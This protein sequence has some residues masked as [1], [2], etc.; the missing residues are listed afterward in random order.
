MI[1]L[2]VESP[3][4]GRT[5][6]RF[7]GKNYKVV[8][9]FGHVRDL[10][11][12][13]LG[14][15]VEKN[16]EPKYV[17]P[18]KA[19]KV[20]A[21]LKKEA[22]L[23]D[24][25]ILATDQ[26]REGE[27]ISWHLAEA[28]N[29]KDPKRIVFH[30]ITKSAIAEALKTPGKIDMH[31]VDAQQARRVLDR[32]VGYKLSPF[33]WKKISKGLSAGRVQSVAVRLVV[34]REE[35]IKKFIAEEYWEIEAIFNKENKNFS[36]FLIKK[37]GKIIDKLEIKNKKHADEILVGLE[38]AKYQIEKITKKETKRN[39]LPPFTTSTMQQTAANKFHFTAKM[40]M[41]VAQKLYEQGHITYHRTDS[42]NLS[43]SSLIA[44]EEFIKKSFGNDYFK[45]TLFKA[46]GNAQEAHEAIRPTYADKTPE[47]MKSELEGA[48]L[49]LYTL[50][51]QR[52]IAS[53]MTPAI[54]DS[55]SIEINGGNGYI[56]GANG[57]MLKFDGFLKIYPMKF[58]ENEM[59]KLQEKEILELV[60]INPSQHYTEPPSRYNEASLIKALESHGIGR[61]STYAPTLS[62]IQD[63]NYIAKNE[64]KRFAPTEMGTIVNEMLVKNFPQIVDIEFTA[65]MEKGLDEIAEG[66]DVWEKI[67]GDFYG[68]FAKN[69]KEKYDEI[70]KEDLTIKTDKKC[71]KCGKDMVDKMGRFGRFYACTG[72]PDC[73][74]TE[75]IIKD[76]PGAQAIKIDIIC[77]KC[78]KGQ[79]VA[80]KTRRGKIFYGCDDYPKCDFAAWDKPI[81]E[82]CPTC[83]L[84]LVETKSKK[85]KCS[86]KDC[87][88][89]KEE[90]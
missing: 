84:I 82:F 76:N 35:E 15:N 19:K 28:L 45:G 20:I 39:P 85:V 72:F 25:V 21:E 43:Q 65:K 66:K 16:F 89:K 80:K 63:R 79:V 14:V 36:A 74:H 31:L 47:S 6:S 46:K 62:T 2:V 59:P 42:L 75:S 55:T 52:F 38:N 87:D 71:P 9:S 77:P 10:P 32:I 18:T 23:A 11:K 86:S 50:I 48:Q 67:V 8:A 81:N 88:F 5:I 29:L 73:K 69:L 51:W 56:F 53:Q 41:S 4:K 90:A 57:Q 60:K 7:L 17:I 58:S 61:P 3:T 49:K 40:T 12:R 54:F 37:D 83:G 44:S 34:E 33:L 78:K 24:E 70:P 26:D 27:S 13:E 22:K 30:E 68:P 64:Q 1:L